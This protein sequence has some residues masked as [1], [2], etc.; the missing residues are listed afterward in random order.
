MENNSRN[1][2][3]CGKG[4]GEFDHKVLLCREI[5]YGRIYACLPLHDDIECIRLFT[6]RYGK[7]H[8]Y[9]QVQQSLNGETGKIAQKSCSTG[10]KIREVVELYSVKLLESLLLFN[11]AVLFYPMRIGFQPAETREIDQQLA[12]IIRQGTLFDNIFQ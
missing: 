6:R 1:C 4:M 9:H 10:K 11:K 2:S 3:G 8:N 7:S 12:Y 5:Q